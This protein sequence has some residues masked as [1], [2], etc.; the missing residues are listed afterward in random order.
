MLFAGLAI[1]AGADQP[2]R[3][4]APVPVLDRTAAEPFSR[5]APF[6]FRDADIFRMWYWSCAY[7]SEEEGRVHYNTV[8]RYAESPDGLQ[9]RSRGDPCI[10]PAGPSDY[11]VG[12]P[13]VVRD[14]ALYK[15]WYSI[16]STAAVPYRI[17]YA[18][19]RDADVWTRKDAEVG[20]APSADGWDAEMIC[21]PCVVDAAG[22]RYMFYNGNRHGATGFG[23]AVLES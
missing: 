14:D 11:A 9:W 15:M 8:I 4:Y 20:I 17:G 18:E 12:R 5:S 6:V 2:F 22:R 7:W 10:T 3:K 19:S 16:R 1:A 21:Y 23:C 13:W